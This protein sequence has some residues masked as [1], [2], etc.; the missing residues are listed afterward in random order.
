V[1]TDKASSVEVEFLPTIASVEALD[2]QRLLP[3]GDSNVVF[4]TREWQQA[5]WDTYGRGQLLFAAAR[6][7]GEVVAVAPLFA[8]ED[9]MVYFV[10]SG[11][12]GSDY[13]D[14]IGDISGPRR[15]DALLSAVRE[16]VGNFVGFRFYFIPDSSRTGKRLEESASRLGLE[17]YEE[18]RMGAPVLDLSAPGAAA[19]ATSKKSLRR[20][21]HYFERSGNLVEHEISSA[22]EILPRLEEFFDQHV[23]RWASTPFP[24]LFL[25]RAHREFYRRVVC[26][27]SEAG[28]LR[29]TWIEWQDRM[30]A[31]HFG[32]HYNRRYLWYKPSFAIDLAQRSPGEVLL[33]RLLLAAIRESADAFDFGLGDERFKQRFA[34]ST[35]VVRTLGLYATGRHQA[36]LL[37]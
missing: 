19:A 17:F 31:A 32:F 6:C 22:V 5:W 16:R 23:A 14:F 18:D 1:I 4:L 15:L 28:W 20:H 33:R 37:S 9:G 2:W 24:S 27:A 30:I 3:L 11:G 35:P 12:C 21:E 7:R 26:E 36:A 29:F 34:T 25:K 10:G 8:D 13:L